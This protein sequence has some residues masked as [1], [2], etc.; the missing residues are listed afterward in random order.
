VSVPA[1]GSGRVLVTG[2]AGFI[3]HHVV[4]LLREQG[5]PVRVLVLRGEDTRNLAGLDVERVEG[6]VLD[7]GSLSRAMEGCELVFHLAAIYRTWVPDPRLTWEVNVAGTTN[8]LACAMERRVKRVVCTSSIAGIGL[9]GDGT[10]SD[11]TARFNLWNDSFDYVRSKWLGQEVALSFARVMDVVVVNPGMPMGPGDIGPTPTGKTLIDTLKGRHKLAF[12][13]GLN[14]VDVEDVARGHLLAAEKGARGEKYLLSGHNVGVFEFVDVLSRVT[15][16]PLKLARVPAG[17]VVR[18]GAVMES[19]ADN[20][21]KKEPIA[22]AGSVRYASQKLY[23]DNAKAKRELG[24][25]VRPLEDTI[26]R[27]VRWFRDHGYL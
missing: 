18:V 15:G 7:R 24:Y 11:E 4:R 27:S 23:F 21:T 3:G 10:P 1:I 8:V 26:R 25:T 5:R 12:D 13:G 22:T 17:L 14:I 20:V 19:V 16:T 9:S 6:D 2:G